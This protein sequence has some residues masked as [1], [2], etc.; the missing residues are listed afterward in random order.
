MR[1][2]KLLSLVLSL[3]LCLSLTSLALAE[4]GDAN[5]VVKITVAGAGDIYA[6]LYP[7]I[8]P[9]TVANFLK[10]VDS[11]FYDG[12][13]FHRVISGFMIQGGDPLG[14]GTGGSDENIKGEFS[15]NGVENPLS[16]TRGVLSMAR[17]SDPDSASS[18][19]FIV[20]ADSPHLDGKYAAFGKVLA[21]MGAVDR[22]ATLTQ[23]MDSNGTVP[24]GFKP[25][26]TAIARAERA[27]AEAA[28]AAEAENGKSGGRF[29]NPTGNV[30]FPVPEGWNLQV[31]A[32]GGSLFQNAEGKTVMLYVRDEY[33][34]YPEEFMA[35][36][37]FT[38]ETL[39][40]SMINTE[41]LAQSLGIT[42]D[43][44]TTETFTSGSY[45]SA[46]DAQGRT[47][48]IGLVNG[49]MIEIVQDSP[50]AEADALTA[51]LNSL[52]VE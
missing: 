17:S 25:V 5:P 34:S 35:A 1:L 37:G 29:V 18:Q 24:D 14:N 9:I 6:E 27:D 45:F 32:N 51:I 19:F 11:G 2:N 10:L 42:A 21:G 15:A 30:S 4:G 3:I 44:L 50:L 40:N 39:D 23:T 13:T 26:I 28:V 38:R 12:L 47:H 16:H 49:V 52:T 46:V 20:H 36:N 7:D 22:V 43:A 41:A 31:S 33:G 8:A 48:C